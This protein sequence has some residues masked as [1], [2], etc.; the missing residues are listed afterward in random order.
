MIVEPEK[1]RVGEDV[2]V[3]ASASGSGGIP[4]YHLRLEGEDDAQPLVLKS[5]KLVTLN[6]LG[7]PVRWELT[8]VTRGEV[9]LRISVYY[10]VVECPDDTGTGC[11]FYFTLESAPSIEVEVNAAWG[12]ASCNNVVDAIDAALVLQRIAALVESLECGDAA[13]VD[14][15]GDAD[16]TDVALILQYVAG[17]IDALPA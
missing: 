7:V 9:E 17:L 11:V 3:T 13:D 10:E 2:N 16:A 8:A 15:D 1:P 12:D 4:G 14:G 5:D 6:Q